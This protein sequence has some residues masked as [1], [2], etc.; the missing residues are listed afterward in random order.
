[1]PNGYFH[2][3]H[4]DTQTRFWIN[5]PSA[6]DLEKA[7]AAGAV[8]CTTN[9]SY[10]SKLLQSEPKYIRGVIDQV[11]KTEKNTDRAAMKVYHTVSA[12]IMERFLPLY[13]A[14]GG[15]EGYVT[16]Q[17]DPRRDYDADH[18]VKVNL[19][20]AKL[21]RNFMAKIPV[22]SGGSEA[23]GE[24]VARNI[25]VCATEIF[26]VSQAV[27]I[28]ERYKKAAKKSGN[29]PP[30]YVTHITGIFDQ[31]FADLVRTENISID[32][33][34]LAQ[35]GTVIARKQYKVLKQR[36]YD[37]LMLGGGARHLG[38]FT[39]FVGGDMHV[40][41]NWSTAAE[42]IAKDP[43][44]ENRIDLPAPKEVVREL[45]AKLPG[46]R[47][48]YE[49]DGMDL[50]EFADFGPVMLFK[51]MFLN[52]YIRLLDEVIDRRARVK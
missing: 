33:A 44:A 4:K 22:I 26:S 5:N 36:G 51:T 8:N 43:P 45:S 30:F 41:I 17:D 34:I 24:L 37:G 27:H 3:V 9:P 21:G 39:E 52:G 12:R 1:M 42:L 31:Y 49:D 35:A 16:I 40:T 47:R 50:G 2:R 15:K 6:D 23:I 38:H 48:A 18:T 46:F 29:R 19:K 11:V 10:C 20:A 32:P 13:K 7:I 25:P 14:S 28:C